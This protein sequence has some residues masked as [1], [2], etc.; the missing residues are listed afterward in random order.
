MDEVARLLTL[1]ALASAALTLLGG[2]A[3]WFLD[4]ERRIRRSL[5]K[6]LGG[7]PQAVLTAPGRG[8]GIGFDFDGEAVAVTWDVG[9]WCLLYS[10]S[11]LTAVELIVDSH[12]AGRAQRGA[13]GRP[14][15]QLAQPQELVRLGFVFDDPRWPDFELDLWRPEDEGRRGRRSAPEALRE[16]NRWLARMEALLRRPIRPRSAARAGPPP[17]PPWADDDEDELAEVVD[18]R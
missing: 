3:V 14:L 4:E 5:R 2:A 12:V 18:A 9:A 10:A 13:P 8:K 16:A 11:E 1:L 17:P 15:D 7:E 6:V